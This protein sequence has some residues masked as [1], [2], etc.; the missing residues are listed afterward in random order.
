MS[1][2]RPATTFSWKSPALQ[3]HFIWHELECTMI[4]SMNCVD[5]L[6]AG[7]GSLRW[8]SLERLIHFDCSHLYYPPLL[9][10]DTWIGFFFEGCGFFL[11]LAKQ[12]GLRSNSARCINEGL[13][14]TA[15][16]GVTV[17]SLPWCG[18]AQSNLKQSAMV[19]SSGYPNPH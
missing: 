6:W 3:Y 19:R 16:V 15:W 7:D 13:R 18:L 1:W 10:L 5:G 17:A 14:R 11:V 4:L 2:C 9:A 12:E 8:G